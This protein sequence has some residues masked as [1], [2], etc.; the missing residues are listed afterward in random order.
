MKV[1]WISRVGSSITEQWHS[2]NQVIFC[3]KIVSGRYYCFMNSGEEE[4]EKGI[5]IYAASALALFGY[6]TFIK[7]CSCA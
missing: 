5:P 1:L 4:N 2:Q 6:L 7:F 3:S